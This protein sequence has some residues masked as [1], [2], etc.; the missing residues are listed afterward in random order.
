MKKLFQSVKKPLE[1]LFYIGLIVAVLYGFVAGLTACA[2][3]AGEKND[4]QVQ[5]NSV[6]AS[7][8]SEAEESQ[9]EVEKPEAEEIQSE[10]EVADPEPE[11]TVVEESEEVAEVVE[12]QPEETAEEIDEFDLVE[13][14]TGSDPLVGVN[15]PDAIPTANLE[16]MDGIEL[17]SDKGWIEVNEPQNSV[18]TLEGYM[19]YL[20]NESPEPIQFRTGTGFN[21]ENGRYNVSAVLYEVN[22]LKALRE[23]TLLD[24]CTENKSKV[25]GLIWNGSELLVDPDLGNLTKMCD[26]KVTVWRSESEDTWVSPDLVE[27]GTD[28]T[29]PEIGV[30]DQ[31]NPPVVVLEPGE[32][33]WA[34][35]DKGQF[36][37][38]I[39]GISPVTSNYGYTAWILNDSDSDITFTFETGWNDSQDP[40]RWNVSFTVF[41]KADADSLAEYAYQKNTDEVKINNFAFIFDGT[42]L[43][44]E[45]VQE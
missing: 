8:L 3:K 14:S 13:I 43:N 15:D 22:S 39:D 40:P 42:S 44:E 30:Y 32:A 10:S 1:F 9:P 29:L 34:S 7:G 6:D 45:S 26:A 18:H 27:K 31:S 20:L 38:D 37:A 35:S 41:S 16:P 17:S 12:P 19:L 11:E 25:I 33:L 23:K 21:E 5:T 36:T 2:A 28:L 4:Q 24:N